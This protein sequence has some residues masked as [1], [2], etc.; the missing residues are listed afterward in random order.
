MVSFLI[1]IAL[2]FLGIFLL[3]IFLK[4]IL[5]LPDILKKTRIS[6]L[7]HA[8]P[9]H[10]EIQREKKKLEQLSATGKVV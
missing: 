10:Q 6:H 1:F 9:A 8:D 4:P 3:S 7:F 2:L 5:P